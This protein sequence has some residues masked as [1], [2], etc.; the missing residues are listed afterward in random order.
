[1]VKKVVAVALVHRRFRKRRSLHIW[2]GGE[3][4][5]V[6]LAASHHIARGV[7]ISRLAAC[8]S[9]NDVSSDNPSPA[10]RR[11]MAHLEKSHAPNLPELGKNSGETE[12]AQ[13]KSSNSA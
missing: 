11:L 7:S 13:L 12:A 8:V 4:P 10:P 2:G 9:S 6:L 5:L 3:A 1:M